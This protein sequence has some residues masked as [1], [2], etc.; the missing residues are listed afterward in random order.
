MKKIL[1]P[2]G[3]FALVDDEDF[4]SLNKYK[5]QYMTK[6]YAARH[7]YIGSGH[8]N[9][10]GRWIHMHRILA[11]TPD[12]LQVDHINHNKLDNRK[13]NLRNVTNQQNHF[14]MPLAKNNTSGYKGIYWF[15][16]D[17]IWHAQITVSSKR[18]HLGYFDDIKKAILARRKAEQKYY[19][20]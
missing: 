5:W 11:N 2:K 13:S 7:I 1:L 14:N 6:G 16:R 17:G 15:R 3:K 19:A 4:E 10:K 18:I 12:N 8:K 9:R 20:I